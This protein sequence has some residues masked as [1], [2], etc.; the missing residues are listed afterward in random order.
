[1][2]ELHG[3]QQ[4]IVQPSRQLTYAVSMAP[5]AA[6]AAAVGTETAAGN[7]A[8]V[9]EPHNSASQVQSVETA[10]VRG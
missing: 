7:G 4:R 8:V 9:A 2:C 6:A 1:M 3:T 5:V 10:T